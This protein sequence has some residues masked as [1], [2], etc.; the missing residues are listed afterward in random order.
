MEN[1]ENKVIFL[2]RGSSNNL[3]LKTAHLM[4]I[5]KSNLCSKCSRS[6]SNQNDYAVFLTIKHS[7]KY[8]DIP[9]A[10]FRMWLHLWMIDSV[11]V[12]YN[13]AG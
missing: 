8:L 1:N 7:Y 9:N 10:G 11:S 4:F 13:Q 5:P 3:H 12:W 2:H 6:T